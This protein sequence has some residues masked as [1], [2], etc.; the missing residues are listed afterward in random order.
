MFKHSKWIF[1]TDFECWQSWI[2]SVLNI[3]RAHYCQNLCRRFMRLM[4]NHNQTALGCREIGWDAND[5]SPLCTLTSV[6]VS[7][8]TITGEHQ[9]FLLSS[10]SGHSVPLL[11]GWCFI[12]LVLFD[13]PVVLSTSPHSVH[14]PTTQSTVS[15][16][17]TIVWTELSI[18]ICYLKH[19]K[20]K[21]RTEL[22]IY[23]IKNTEKWKLEHS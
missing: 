10:S 14:S 5:R 8:E 21:T 4:W 15:F 18:Y 3:S 6:H 19:W 16:K 1:F 17:V 12:C 13:K 11:R 2:W 9:P 23:G 7:N 22:A 20:M